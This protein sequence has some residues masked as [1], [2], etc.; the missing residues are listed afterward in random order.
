VIPSPD[1]VILR[2]LGP[3]FYFE[4]CHNSWGFHW[5]DDKSRVI[6]H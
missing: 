3:E 6:Y 2:I 4:T 1:Q 5:R